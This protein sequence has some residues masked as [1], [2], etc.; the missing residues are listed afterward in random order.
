MK[1]IKQLQDEITELQ[2]NKLIVGKTYDASVLKEIDSKKKQ[3]LEL[4]EKE[5][6]LLHKPTKSLYR[7]TE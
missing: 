2:D 7:V 5:L 3:V 1:T 6:A 4:F